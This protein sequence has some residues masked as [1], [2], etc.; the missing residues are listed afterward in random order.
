MVTTFTPYAIQTYDVELRNNG[1]IEETF[2]LTYTSEL[3]TRTGALIPNSGWVLEDFITSTVVGA[4]MTTTVK[5]TVVVPFLAENWLTNTV[6]VIASAPQAGSTSLVFTTWTGG[7]F[8]ATHPA[9]ARY[10]GCRF[11]TNYELNVFLA[12]TIDG[13]DAQSLAGRFNQR[14]GQANYDR[15]L[16]FNYDLNPFLANVLDGS[17]AQALAGRF[18]NVCP[19]P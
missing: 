2:S 1:D 10:V 9:G 11:D 12:G 3:Y 19:N 13:A 14:V 5:I 6:E 7:I 15:K 16:D 8:N 17:D 18:N 4:G